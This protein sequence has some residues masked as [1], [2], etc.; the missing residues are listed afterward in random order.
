MGGDATPKSEAR[1]DRWLW[2]A[3][4]FKTRGLAQ[5]A[6]RGGHVEV[7]GERAKPARMVRVGQRVSIVKGEETWHVDITGIAE[8]RG[9]TAVART[10]YRETDESVEA[11]ARMAQARRLRSLQGFEPAEGARPD[12]RDRR[13]RQEL[14]DR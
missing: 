14:R 1:L 3:R 7:N 4:F 2:A 8:R 5:A 9:S 10:L 6:V 11:R 13:A 12:R